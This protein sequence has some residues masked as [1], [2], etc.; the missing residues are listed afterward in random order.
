MHR[1][2]QGVGAHRVAQ[3]VGQPPGQVRPKPSPPMK[4]VRTVEMAR[5]VDPNTSVSP[6][7]QTISRISPEAP[8]RKKQASTM[9]RMKGRTLYDRRRAAGY[10][11]MVTSRG[12]MVQVPSRP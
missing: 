9:A 4:A 12:A 7:V 3:A 10:S 5:V 1:L 11:E 6:R 8:D 2:G